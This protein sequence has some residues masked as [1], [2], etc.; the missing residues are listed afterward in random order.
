MT[1]GGQSDR[2]RVCP[3]LD[4]S[5][6]WRILARDR[7]SEGGLFYPPSFDSMSRSFVLLYGYE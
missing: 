4:N 7:L 6:Q 3:L 5:G 2:A 1:L